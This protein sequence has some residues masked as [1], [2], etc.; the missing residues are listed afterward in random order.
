M[1]EKKI[2]IKTSFEVK[3][4]NGSEVKRR[5]CDYCRQNGKDLLV[6]GNCNDGDRDICADCINQFAIAIKPKQS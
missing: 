4:V 2:T 3:I 6:N 1:S 5:L